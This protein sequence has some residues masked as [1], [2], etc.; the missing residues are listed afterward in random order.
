MNSNTINISFRT[1]LPSTEETIIRPMLLLYLLSRGV[2]MMDEVVYKWIILPSLWE[3]I[4]YRYKKT[5]KL[6]CGKLHE[7]DI[8]QS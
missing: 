5:P 7:G 1:E 6:P 4:G 8:S 3:R 2:G